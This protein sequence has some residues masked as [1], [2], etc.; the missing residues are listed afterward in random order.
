MLKECALIAITNLGETKNLGF[1]HMK[2][3]MPLVYVR[4]AISINIIKYYL[5][6]QA[7]KQDGAKIEFMEFFRTN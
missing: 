6:Y 7:K 2:N 5:H 4:T 3:Y 1:A